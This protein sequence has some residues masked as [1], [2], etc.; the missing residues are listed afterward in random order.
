M[1]SSGALF[2][3]LDSI[4]EHQSFKGLLE[5]V[6]CAR[7]RAQRR[8]EKRENGDRDTYGEIPRRE[9]RAC[10]CTCTCACPFVVC[11][12]LRATRC[13]FVGQR[14]EGL[15]GEYIVRAVLACR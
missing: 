8:E 12:M 1:S 3:L 15:E 10:T 14:V 6:R 7:R 9:S 2:G 4:K 5:Y 11:S 13:V